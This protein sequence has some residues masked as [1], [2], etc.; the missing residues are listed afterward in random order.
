VI[1]YSGSKRITTAEEM[2]KVYGSGAYIQWSWQ[3]LDEDRFGVISV[4][5]PKLIND[6]FGLVLTPDD[7]DVKVT[8]SCELII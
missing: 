1:L 5:D 3:R 2:K 7:V 8:F 4:D 6:G